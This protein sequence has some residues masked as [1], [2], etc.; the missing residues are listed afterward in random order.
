MGALINLIGQKFGRLTVIEKDKIKYK[1]G[2]VH[3]ICKCQCGKIK[4]INGASLRKGNTTSCG[5][6]Q[7]QNLKLNLTGKVFGRLTVLEQAE[8]PENL[9]QKASYWLCKCDCGTKKIIRGN[10]LTNGQIKSCGCMRKDSTFKDLTGQKFGLLTAKYPL[11]QKASDG[12]TIWFC[13]CECGGTTQVSVSNLLHNKV[14]S[15]GC[16]RI[17]FGEKEITDL[18]E[19]NNIKF[20]REYIFSDLL[21]NKNSPLR[22]DFCIFNEDNSINRLIEFQ[23]LQHYK[24]TNFFTSPKKNDERKKQ[25]CLKNNLTLICIPYWIQNKITLNDLFSNKYNIVKE[26]E[27]YRWTCRL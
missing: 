24:E 4:S 15:C 2:S 23:G 25:Y 12:G 6:G 21:G 3:W 7:P 11:N 22:F 1:D 14:R 8:K 13:I 16:H 17:S 27:G 5:C 19:Q 20:K 10:L 9:S 26:D 18:L